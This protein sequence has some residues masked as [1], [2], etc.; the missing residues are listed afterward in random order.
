M[1]QA[2]PSEITRLL[3]EIER[4][5]PGAVDQL[6]GLVYADLRSIAENRMRA[7]PNGD[8]LQPTAMV[9]EVYLRI[10]GK[11]NPSWPDRRYFFRAAATAVRDI[12]VERA[13][14]AVSLK[15]GGGRERVPLGDTALLWEESESALRLSEALAAL[16]ERHPRQHEVV[17]LKHFAMLT[18]EEIGLTLGISAVTVR[19][20]WAFARAW[21]AQRLGGSRTA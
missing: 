17:E 5:T 19:R 3:H 4:Q 11:P 14:R 15:R 20:D 2:D 1:S 10:F 7:T 6:I 21:L 13:R 18:E 12:L 8:S 9:H 16:G